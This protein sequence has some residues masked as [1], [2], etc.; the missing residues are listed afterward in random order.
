VRS[1][2]VQ[3]VALVT[4]LWLLVLLS[5]I[6]GSYAFAVRTE[7]NMARNNVQAGRARLLAEAGLNRAIAEL[8]LPAGT[9]R[10]RVDGAPQGFTLAAG[11]ITVR[12]QAAAGLVDLNQAPPALL[13]KLLG[14]AG[15]ADTRRD[16]LVDAILDWRDGDD[17]RRLN[18][19]EERAYR[20][21]DRGY[22]P[23]NRPFDYTGELAL[24]L[25]MQPDIHRRLR[26]LVTVHSGGAQVDR[27][28]AP[29][30]VLLVMLDG[31][32]DAV[33]ALLDERAERAEN[34]Q[35]AARARPG[36]AYHVLV[37]ARLD[38]GT[39]AALSA[40]VAINPK[41]DV[42]YAVLDWREGET[43]RRGDDA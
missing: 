21:A 24:V 16:R 31:D 20:L 10:W 30:A 25:G 12:L 29:R 1:R 32:T 6:A 2:A 8:L 14:A 39:T 42:P 17:L 40:V 3:G 13:A 19:A 38:D 4:V 33:D 41:P 9:A 36:G 23:A 18:G 11:A 15:A 26:P 27:N 22:K 35:Q 5:T 37:Q 28:V 43:V 34:A 7:Y